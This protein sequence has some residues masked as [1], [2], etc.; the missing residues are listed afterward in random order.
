MTPA[1]AHID[2]TVVVPVYFNEGSLTEVAANL[3][4][5]IL[6]GLPNH[7]G[8]ILFVDDGSG[9]G[10][11][12][13]LRTLQ[14]QHPS[15]IRVVKLS[16]NFGSQNACWCG[17]SLA[18]GAVLILS[19]DGQEPAASGRA[20]LQAHLEEGYEVVFGARESRDESAYRKVTSRISYWLLRRLSFPDLPSSGVDVFALGER[21]RRELLR[22]Y[23]TQGYLTGQILRLGF[24]RKTVGYPRLARKHG[25]SRW[26]FS[27]KLT[28]LLDGIFGYSFIP[29]RA[30]SL[31]GALF[32]LLGMIY[33]VALG[34]SNLVLGSPVKGWTALMTTVLT[35]GG[36]QMFM[37]GMIGEYLWRTFA[38]VRGVSPYI[39][40]DMID[41][42]PG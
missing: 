16:R 40:E 18:R 17:I 23:H 34:V 11:F 10:S 20:M 7:A 31:I 24:R 21:A 28:H 5:E 25:T 30:I 6:E 27:R 26:S 35:I 8:Q 12:E 32:A 2:Y 29:I 37:L 4:Q 22:N 42:T 39:V 3:R 13:V 33:A 38:Q 36:L 1:P 19:A 9:D 14:A 15:D 41:A